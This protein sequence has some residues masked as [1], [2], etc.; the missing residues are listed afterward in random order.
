MRDELHVMELVDRYLDVAM[1]EV[2][3][4]A[5]E[6]RMDSNADLRLLVNDQRALRE[7]M[8]RVHLRR[9][10]A[11]ARRVWMFRRMLP[12]LAAAGLILATAASV[13]L[14]RDREGHD[15]E[16]ED[17]RTM[18]APVE[19]VLTNADSSEAS[20]VEELKVETVFVQRR[21]A[22]ERIREHG[23]GESLPRSP[24]EV[25]SDARKE[26]I[27]DGSL[28]FDVRVRTEHP[29]ASDSTAPVEPNALTPAT[30]KPLLATVEQPGNADHQPSYP[31][32][33]DAMHD[34][35]KA[36]LHVPRNL[37]GS[38]TVLVS[39]V[40]DRKG[41]IRDPKVLESGSAKLDKEALRVIAL[42]PRWE[43]CRV[44]DTPVKSRIEVP[45]RF[46]GDEPGVH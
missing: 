46:G 3:R 37:R 43:P 40:V 39:F 28:A 13:I 35:L 11:G 22:N 9:A 15:Q 32:G 21:K 5:F 23:H 1:G 2:E 44:G 6:Q 8:L 12:W 19:G 42:M 45:I 27:T 14:N 25:S 30:V 36:N 16:V 24:V 17:H 18:I 41:V 4:S 10:A 31:G 33:W 7:G 29:A 26:Q 20:D 38:R 34:F